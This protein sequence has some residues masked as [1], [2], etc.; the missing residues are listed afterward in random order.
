MRYRYRYIIEFTADV[1][2]Q[3]AF[4]VLCQTSQYVGESIDTEDKEEWYELP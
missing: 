2:P 4:N 3:E 1:D